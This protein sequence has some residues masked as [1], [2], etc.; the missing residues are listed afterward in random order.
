MRRGVVRLEEIDDQGPLIPAIPTK[1]QAFAVWRYS[2]RR[3]RSLS[4]VFLAAISLA[5][6]ACGA[7]A[8]PAPAAKTAKSAA[9]MGGVDAVCAAGKAE[10]Q[11]E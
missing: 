6:T 8:T 11:D 9:D 1:R 3:T 4:I 10:G 7:A 2:V 5:A